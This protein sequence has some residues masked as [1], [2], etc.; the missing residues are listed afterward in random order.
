MQSFLCTQKFLL[1]ATILLLLASFLSPPDSIAG[2]MTSAGYTV[3]TVV[4]S[5]GGG[6]LGSPGYTAAT[7]IGLPSPIGISRST[8]YINQ[9]GFWFRF[10]ANSTLTQRNIL[11]LA[12]PAILSEPG[13]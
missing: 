3:K 5:S 11:W 6:V 13:K 12:L 10:T 4:L 8:S 7:T 2:E 1:S 9:A